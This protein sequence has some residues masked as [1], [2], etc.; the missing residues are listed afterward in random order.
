MTSNNNDLGGSSE[1]PAERQR[2]DMVPAPKAK[3]PSRN[4]VAFDEALLTESRE[5]I[6][7]RTYVFWGV[8]CAAI[9]IFSMF[10]IYLIWAHTAPNRPIDHLLMWLLAVMPVGLLFV[11]IKLTSEPEKNQQSGMWPEQL[12][13]LGEKLVE[14]AAEIVKKK[15]SGP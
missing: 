14:H 13:K 12:V 2:V 5:R 10:V 8:V 4:Q 15:M 1:I 3:P 7:R 11:L 6:L 9:L